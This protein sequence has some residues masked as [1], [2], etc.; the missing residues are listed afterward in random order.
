MF[1]GRTPGYLCVEFRQRLP[2]AENS[3][4]PEN[5]QDLRTSLTRNAFMAKTIRRLDTSILGS[6]AKSQPRKQLHRVNARLEFTLK[7]K[8]FMLEAVLTKA[9]IDALEVPCVVS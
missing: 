4:H 6:V 3:K 5:P 2:N 8:H 7:I 9:V 1:S